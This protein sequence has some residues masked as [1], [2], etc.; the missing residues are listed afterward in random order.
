[1]SKIPDYSDAYTYV[2]VTIT[3]PNTAAA[4]A[5]VNNTKKKVITLLT[6]Q[7]K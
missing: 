1:M 4:A 5:L 6:T 3:V 7:N 2:K